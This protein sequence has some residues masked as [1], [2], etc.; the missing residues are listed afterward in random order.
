MADLNKIAQKFNITTEQIKL[1]QGSSH[2][3]EAVK[4]K[5][6][7]WL[8]NEVVEEV[9]LIDPND[10]VNWIY[11]DRPENELGDIKSLADEFLSIGQQ[12]P[13]IVRPTEVGNKYK[14]ELIIGERR[15]RAAIAAGIKLK[16]IIK[17]IND[18]ESA[19]AQAAENDNRKDLSDYAKG[20]SY[21][22]LIDNKIITQNDLTEKLGKSKQY[23]SSLLSYSKIPEEII[24]AIGDMSKVSCRTAE[25]IKRLAQRG[26]EHCQVIIS[27]ATLIRSGS[28]GH[29]KL[30]EIVNNYISNNNSPKPDANKIISK[31]GRHIFTWRKDNNNLTS[32]HFPKDISTL[33]SNN[34]IN[35]DVINKQIMELIENELNKIK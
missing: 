32:I 23:V 25:T 2:E 1:S 5:R 35:N 34:S 21:A 33:L 15:W 11:H 16:V 17:E 26:D 20:I 30:T 6:R 31:N 24:S 9:T 28:L 4:N 10:I 27:K 29:N 8:E 22:K 13:C 12:Q 14:Y 19:L 3:H 18:A 7:T